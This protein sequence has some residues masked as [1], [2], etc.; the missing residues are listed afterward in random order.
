MPYVD[1]F[2]LSIPKDKTDAY[3]AQAEQAGAVWR[4]HGALS[5]VECIADDVPYGDVTSFPRAVQAKEGEIVVF[6]WVTYPS[7]AARDETMKK[8]MADPRIQ[9]DPAATLFDPTLLIYGGFEV[10]VQI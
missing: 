4:E 9:M 3:R 5:Y 7:R 10:I 1:G 2:L 8:V 6:A